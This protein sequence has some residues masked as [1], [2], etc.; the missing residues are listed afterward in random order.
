MA[1]ADEAGLPVAVGEVLGPDQGT[2]GTK[3]VEVERTEE[4]EEAAE[5][6]FVGTFGLDTVAL[7]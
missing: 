5:L 1:K 4:A 2:Q 3:E 7:A 6:L